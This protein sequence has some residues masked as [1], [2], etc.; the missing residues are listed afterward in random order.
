MNAMQDE[1]SSAARRKIAD[2]RHNQS[3]TL[4]PSELVELVVV[5]IDRVVDKLGRRHQPNTRPSAPAPVPQ[6]GVRD[7][8]YVGS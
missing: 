7:T 2:R 1:G 4:T 6:H 8:K 3:E 5:S